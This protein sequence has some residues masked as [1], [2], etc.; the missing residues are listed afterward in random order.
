MSLLLA[1]TIPRDNIDLVIGQARF[2][3]GRLRIGDSEVSLIRGTSAMIGAACAAAE[4]FGDELPRAVI[5]GDIGTRSGSR[6][7]YRYLIKHLPKINASVLGLHYIIPDIA[8]H[9]QVIMSIRKMK[10]KPC[11][12][13]DAGFM[14]A[15]KASGFAS[16]YDL[17]LPDLGE[18]AFLADDR[19]MHPAYTRGFLTRLEDDPDRLIERAY[20][21]GSAARYLCV[22]G[23]TDYI[24]FDGRIVEEIQNPVIE[25]LEPIGG[26][27][28][29][30][31]GMVTALVYHGILIPEACSIACRANRLAGQMANVDPATQ[32]DTIISCI[33][34]ALDNLKTSDKIIQYGG[35]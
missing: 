2:A 19:A 24:C 6:T 26:T 4:Y 10:H 11:L 30:I 7:V 21:T 34:A 29:T 23:R 35:M 13:A 15:A 1:G 31:T 32:I 16:D 5:G 12:I 28:D 18:L 3:D 14:Y 17:F 9:N 25:E 27:G 22:K 20:N 8:L 33:P